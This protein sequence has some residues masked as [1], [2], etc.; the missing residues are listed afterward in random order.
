MITLITHFII[1]RSVLVIE[2]KLNLYFTDPITDLSSLQSG[3][4]EYIVLFT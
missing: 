3:I 2:S 1:I 4:K